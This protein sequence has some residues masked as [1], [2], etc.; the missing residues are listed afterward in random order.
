M[1]SVATWINGYYHRRRGID[2]SHVRRWSATAIPFTL[3]SGTAWALLSCRCANAGGGGNG[4]ACVP[5]TL[6]DAPY[7]RPFNATAATVRPPPSA[8]R[9][10]CRW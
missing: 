7:V 10:C 8:G 1:L 5:F 2:C 4:H 9:W 6:H 3:E